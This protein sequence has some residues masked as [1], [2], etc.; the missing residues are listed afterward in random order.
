MQ[1]HDPE[2]ETNDKVNQLAQLLYSVLEKE[3][4][5]P[6]D[7]AASCIMCAFVLICVDLGLPRDIAEKMTNAGYNALINTMAECVGRP[8]LKR[9]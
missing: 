5:V 3:E 7:K 2:A 9:H 6:Q 8:D 1:I 4:Y